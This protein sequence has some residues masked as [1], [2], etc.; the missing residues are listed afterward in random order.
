MSMIDSN[1]R[2]FGRFNLVDAAAVVFVIVL[3]PA[4]YATYLLFRP[5]QPAIESVTRVDPTREEERTAGNQ[6]VAKLKVRGSGFNPLLRARLGDTEALG[7]VFENPNSADV[8]VGR[9]PPGRHDLV[10]YDG[11][12]EVARL[13]EAMEVVEKTAVAPWVRLSGW[14]T[15]LDPKQAAQLAPGFASPAGSANAFRVV[16]A[17]P[18]QP[19]RARITT[20]VNAV[21]LPVPDRVERAAEVLVQC[22]GPIQAGCS[23]GGAGLRQDPPFVVTMAGGTSFYVEEV[24]P[25][26]DAR[27]A[28][29]RVQLEG[30]V[31]IETGDRDSLVGPRAA[32]VISAGG[33]SVTLRLGAD[34]SRDGW[35]YRGQLLTPGA[36]FR[37]RTERYVAA[38]R[39]V[40]VSIADPGAKP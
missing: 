23:I 19:A 33:G 5:A 21:D 16:A 36:P 12:Q 39:V 26:A 35:R 15:N 28:T 6:L 37:F 4:G 24:G 11:V 2:V 25:P 14:L 10:L 9:L 7:F 1:G 22:D 18:P 17:G 32:E 38:G 13:R 34:E 20:A 8:L 31:R 40:S 3:I 27:P 29:V 30:T